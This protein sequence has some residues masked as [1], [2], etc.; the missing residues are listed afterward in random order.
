M[1]LEKKFIYFAGKLAVG[2][3]PVYVFLLIGSYIFQRKLHRENS[4]VLIIRAV[5]RFGSKAAT[6]RRIR[7]IFYSII[8]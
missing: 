4:V 8:V 7:E 5:I 6:F 2:S 1:V 3:W